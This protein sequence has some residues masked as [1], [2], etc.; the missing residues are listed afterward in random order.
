MREMYL[1]Q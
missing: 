1:T